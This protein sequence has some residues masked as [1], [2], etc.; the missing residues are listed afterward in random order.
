[1]LGWFLG[2]L[3]AVLIEYFWGYDYISYYLGLPKIPVLFGTLI[4]LKEPLMIPGALA[5]DL[6]VYVIPVLAVGKLTSP[7]TNQG[8]PCLKSCRYGCPQCCIWYFYMRS[9]IFGPGSMTTGSW[10]SNS[11]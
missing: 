2:I 8:Q 7:L 3:T 5:Y 9:F 10:W 11:P 1:M 6:I 4:M